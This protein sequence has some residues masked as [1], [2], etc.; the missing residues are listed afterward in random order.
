MAG[1]IVDANGHKYTTAAQELRTKEL[2]R[3]LV[4]FVMLKIKEG[5]ARYRPGQKLNIDMRGI[6][7]FINQAYFLGRDDS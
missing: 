4:E 6:E 3:Q 2:T 5:M 7:E 1:L